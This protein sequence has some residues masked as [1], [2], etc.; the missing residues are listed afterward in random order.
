MQDITELQ[1]RLTAAL[2]RIGGSL[3][4]ITRIDEPEAPT[5]AVETETAAIAAELDR[6]RAAIAALEAD[7][8]RLKAVND[9]LRNSNHALREAGTEGGPTADLINSAMQAELDALRAARESDR[10]ELDAIIGLLHPV[11]ADAD[12]EVQNA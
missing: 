7:R 10:A 9:A 12:E 3:D 2:D 4:R 5:E 1:R 11:V 6:S 8:L